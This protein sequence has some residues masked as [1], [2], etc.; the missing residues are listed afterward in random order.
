MQHAQTACAV[1]GA[2]TVAYY[3]SRSLAGVS[4]ELSRALFGRSRAKRVL[5]RKQTEM[6]EQIARALEW[7]ASVPPVKPALEEKI[8]AA[9]ASELVAMQKHKDVT[10]VQLLM[11]FVKRAIVAHNKTNCLVW[12]GIGDAVAQAEAADAKRKESSK[13]L[14]PLHGVPVS[15]K[16]NIDVRGSDSTLGMVRYAFQPRNED[17]A[18]VKLI[19][20]AGGVVFCK[21]NIPQTL[22]A[23]E[24]TNHVFGTAKNPHNTDFACGGSSGGEAALVAACGSVIGIG[25]DIG[26]SIRIPCHFCGIYGLKPSQWRVPAFGITTPMAGQEAACSVAG[27]MARSVDDLV[28]M[29]RVLFNGSQSVDG[30]TIG[31]GFRDA[32]YEAAKKQKKL[33]FGYY[34]DDGFV[35][36]SPACKRALRMAITALEKQGHTCVPIT[37]GGLGLPCVKLMYSLLSADGGRT[38]LG[39][40]G[41]E[42][43]IAPIKNLFAVVLI[44]RALK[45]LASWYMRRVKGDP[46][47][48][49]VLDVAGER[50]VQEYWLLQHERQQ[51]RAEAAAVMEQHGLDAILCPGLVTPAV[52]H[53]SSAQVG[54]GAMMT[55]LLNVLDMPSVVVPVTNVD[56]ATDRWEGPYERAPVIEQRIR[57]MY[58]VE[59]GHGLPVGVQIYG[60][61]T[62]DEALLGYAQQLDAALKA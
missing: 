7:C 44:P 47:I 25:T 34:D 53:G 35:A 2:A 17:A 21:T 57:R 37:P 4:R 45:G 42:P 18:L 39:H 29:S 49:A 50:S 5:D 26:G 36:A 56:R 58:D 62:A 54:Y 1:V 61:K 48:A 31:V 12:I 9:T 38:L 55:G 51:A 3:A 13:D 11:V 22:V 15:I 41:T 14:G 52:P 27:P 30:N 40:L 8:V 16:D 6:E 24:S 10:A 43:I 33:T 59:R 19:K 23:Y 32:V 60:K 28:T 46:F 20:G